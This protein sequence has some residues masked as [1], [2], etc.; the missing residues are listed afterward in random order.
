ME[1][2]I[3]N[4][5]ANSGSAKSKVYEAIESAE[6]GDFEKAESDLRE[7]NDFI[8]K[9]HDTQS[10]LIAQE[11][12]GDKVEISLLFVHAQDHIS[13]AIELKNLAEYIIRMYKKINK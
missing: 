7:A 5:I 8:N 1:E 12:N 13:T 6:N 2:I 4:L 9:A 10:Q 3:F 11:L